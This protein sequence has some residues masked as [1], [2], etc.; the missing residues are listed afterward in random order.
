MISERKAKFIARAAK[1]L[2]PKSP[3]AEIAVNAILYHL[4]N[5]EFEYMLSILRV[6]IKRLQGIRYYF[7]LFSSYENSIAENKYRSVVKW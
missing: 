4:S 6:P 2:T 7:A 3:Q 1:S 5:S